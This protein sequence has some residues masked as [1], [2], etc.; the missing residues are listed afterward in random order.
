MRLT[1]H[2]IGSDDLQMHLSFSIPQDDISC[3]YYLACIVPLEHYIA[4][5][6]AVSISL[7]HPLCRICV[8]E[9]IYVIQD[10]TYTLLPK[11]LLLVTNKQFIDFK[12]TLQS[13]HCML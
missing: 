13:Q 3:C 10:I 8:S 9:V 4:L 2:I 1:W 7:S 11:F 12:G 6:N 5:Y